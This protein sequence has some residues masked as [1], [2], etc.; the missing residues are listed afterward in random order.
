LLRLNLSLLLMRVPLPTHM[1]MHHPLVWCHREVA[2]ERTWLSTMVCSLVYR[3][4][5]AVINR[6]SLTR[7]KHQQI[8]DLSPLN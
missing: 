6:Q 3:N 1:I 8:T 7:W 5:G 4:I 2:S